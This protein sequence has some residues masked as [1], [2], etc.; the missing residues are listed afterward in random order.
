MPVRKPTSL[1]L[2]PY[3]VVDDLQRVS[4]RVVLAHLHLS[5]VCGEQEIVAGQLGLPGSGL[6]LSQALALLS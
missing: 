2:E 4:Y 5:A 3:G 1:T 6:G